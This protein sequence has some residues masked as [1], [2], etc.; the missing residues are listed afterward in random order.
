MTLSVPKTLEI[1]GDSEDS[2]QKL[3]PSETSSPEE[4]SK[5]QGSNPKLGAIFMLI[6][7]TSQALNWFIIKYIYILEPEIHSLQVVFLR[8]AIA[9]VVTALY[10]NKDLKKSMWDSLETEVFKFI[11]IRC[12]Q[13]FVLRII[14][15]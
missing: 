1:A 5:V 7:V 10:V 3:S 4:N 13:G 2:F 11:F 14:M 6:H 15:F 9:T 8:S 12:I